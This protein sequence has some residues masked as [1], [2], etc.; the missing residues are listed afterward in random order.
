M[1]IKNIVLLLSSVGVYTRI[2][3]ENTKFIVFITLKV[4]STVIH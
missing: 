4:L 3:H 1:Y 2:T